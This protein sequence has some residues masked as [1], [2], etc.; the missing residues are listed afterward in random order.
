MLAYPEYVKSIID[1]AH[2]D[3]EF[4]QIEST[5][6]DVVTKCT[7]GLEDKSMT[8]AIGIASQ[9]FESAMDNAW[10]ALYLIP[11]I[12]LVDSPEKW[13]IV[14]SSP[15]IGKDIKISQN[16]SVHVEMLEYH[17]DTIIGSPACVYR[18]NANSR[19]AVMMMGTTVIE[20]ETENGEDM[21]ITN[22]YSCMAFIQKFPF[23]VPYPTV[24]TVI[25]VKNKETGEVEDYGY[26]SDIRNLSRE[27]VSAEDLHHHFFSPVGTALFP[28]AE[29]IQEDTS[30]K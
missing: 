29:P 23:T 7:K 18:I 12:D 26:I 1:L 28:A 27:E 19:L 11:T 30:E 22:S 17:T 6:F 13:Q 8:D 2:T 16:E 20:Y 25:H 14:E 10:K 3:H 4:N 24:T 15:L 5:V 9:K 21:Q